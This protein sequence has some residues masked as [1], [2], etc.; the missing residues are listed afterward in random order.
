MLETKCVDENFKMLVTGL[1]FLVTNIHYLLCV[2]HQ[3]SKDVTNIE[4]QSP[5][6]LSPIFKIWVEN[7]HQLQYTV[8]STQAWT[9]LEIFK[10]FKSTP[11]KNTMIVT[12][13]WIEFQCV[14]MEY[15]NEFLKQISL[16]FVCLIPTM[17][18][19]PEK[20]TINSQTRCSNNP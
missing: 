7:I 4:I 8:I 19:I 3:H 2:W 11:V 17:H 15:Q 20:I 5:T 18:K 16:K 12:L 10:D 1:A 13:K 14:L 6:S 9:T